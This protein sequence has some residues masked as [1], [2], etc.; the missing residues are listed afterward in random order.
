MSSSP[1]ALRPLVSWWATWRSRR[2]LEMRAA[3]YVAALGREPPAGDVEWL[4]TVAADGDLDHARWELRYARWAVGLLGAQRDALDDRTASL[5]ARALAAS[6]A[7]D[8]SIAPGKLRV[9]ERQ[10]NLRLR[11]YGDALT[12]REGA[13]SGWHLGRALLRFA[14][15]SDAVSGE[16]V[17][18][19]G[20][21]LSHYL[22][23]SNASLR[24]QFGEATLPDQAA[25]AV[26]QANPR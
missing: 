19:A 5:V 13:G 12:N 22:A 7:R 17:A 25:H 16:M 10:L 26:M 6:L 23:E 2:A 9:A 20:D 24:V 15:R 14:G 3:A 18:R 8:P 1:V 21:M 11:T 4:A